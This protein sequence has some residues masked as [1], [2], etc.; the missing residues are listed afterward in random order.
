MK[1][2]YQ[3]AQE[4][5]E[6]REYHLATGLVTRV[7]DVDNNV[8]TATTFDALGRPTLVTAAEGKPEETKTGYEYSD[9]LR[10]VITRSDLNTSGDGKLVSIQQY[11]QLGRVRL[12]RQLEDAASQSATD[13]TKGIKVQTRYRFSGS[14]SYVVI[15]NAYRADTSS[16]ASSE[17]TM[18]WTR[19]K[20][21]NAGKHWKCRL[22][23]VPGCRLRGVPTPPPPEL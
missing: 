9:L 20:N 6:T 10:R 19:S 5:T 14:N 2:A 23:V 7:T 22:L 18:G 13:E 16:L 8:S 11:D 17:P 21:D 3:T 1:T 4:R 12:S 15:S